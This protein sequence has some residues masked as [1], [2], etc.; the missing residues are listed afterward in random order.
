[1]LKKAAAEADQAIRDSLP[2]PDTECEHEFSLSFQ[3]KMHRIF[4]KAKHPTIYKLPQYAACFVL[5]VALASGTW[6]T[7]D[8]EAR[9]AFFAWVHEQYETF[10]EY[11]FVGDTTQ[12]DKSKQYELTQLPDGFFEINRMESKGNAVV[13]YQNESG[14]TIQFTYSQGDDSI[15][16]FLESSTS[17]VQIVRIGNID[18]EFYPSSD[19]DISNGLVWQSEDGNTFFCITS[20]LPQDVMLRLAESVQAKK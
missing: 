18:A 17:D 7:V 2:A 10:I 13:I 6:L 8:A 5:V 14:K 3:R 12:N 4:R 11:R 1:M 16:L 20:T 9:D 15:S 19:P